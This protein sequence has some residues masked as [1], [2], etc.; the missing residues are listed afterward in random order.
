M[1][2]TPGAECIIWP[3]ATMPDGYGMLRVHGK[4][5]RVHRE[6][7]QTF[8]PAPTGKICSVKGNWISGDRLQ[9]SHGPCHKPLCVNP[10]HLSWQTNAENQADRRRDG[11]WAVVGSKLDA[12]EVDEIRTKYATGS[13]RQRELADEYGVSR[14]AVNAV[15][16]GR[17]WGAA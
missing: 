13:Y 5:V 1:I 4:P 15:V 2:R 9:A 7:L 12:V 10:L 14:Q 3:H 8:S 17:S 16:T 6:A 11:T